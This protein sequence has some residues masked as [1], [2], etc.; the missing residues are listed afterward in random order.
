M[1][2]YTDNGAGMCQCLSYAG[3]EGIE[4][5]PQIIDEGSIVLL[6]QVN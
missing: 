5:A 2:M 4:V 6:L 3:T 1:Y